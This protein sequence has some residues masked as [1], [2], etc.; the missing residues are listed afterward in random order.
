MVDALLKYVE[1]QMARGYSAQAIKEALVRQG[2]SPA[3][4]DG[5]IDSVNMRKNSAQAPLPMGVSHEKSSF[6]K[7]I[8][9]LLFVG[10][11]V[12]GAILVP[13]MFR[14]KEPLLDVSVTP[15]KMAYA[16]GED[17]GFDL[18]ITNMGSAERFDVTITYR[19]FDYD[20]NTIK[21]QEET[22]AISTSMS[23]HR[24]IPLPLSMAPGSYILKVFANYEGKIATTAFSFEVKEKVNMPVES[25]S[26]GIRNQDETNV[27]CGGTCGG[28][29]YDGGCHSS[30][31][32]ISNNGS[33]NT[34]PVN[35]ATCSD[36]IR[37]QDETNVDCGG[38]C[39]GYWYDNSCHSS[40]KSEAPI[41]PA[42][43]PKTP[44]QIIMEA[45][46][47]AKT[48]PDQAKEICTTL[49]DAKA[50]DQC[51][52]R[53][54]PVANDATICEL[55]VD[56]N[57]KDTCYYPF[58]MQGDYTVCEKLTGDESKQACNQLRELSLIAAQMQNNTE[59]SE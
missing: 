4:V 20:D 12:A 44:A 28:Y 57:E 48:N 36:G 38:K 29:W 17:L 42:E 5:V 34:V 45:Q 10:I 56:V 35:K 41:T 37:N 54:A 25:C 1:E 8:I 14:P 11:I 24:A 52:K 47:A 26:D 13:G 6:P 27:D 23:H 59:T 49:S 33:N 18:E 7:I 39:G 46:A 9:I 32:T 53:I 50:K 43:K 30:P 16:P 2:Y 19:I 40:P 22:L 31:K 51:Y 58:F 3:L 15:D 21:S 55:I